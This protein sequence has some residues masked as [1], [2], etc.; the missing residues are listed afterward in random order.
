MSA[1]IVAASSVAMIQAAASWYVAAA[2]RVEEDEL[3]VI[4]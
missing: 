4:E 1:M 3:H 2:D